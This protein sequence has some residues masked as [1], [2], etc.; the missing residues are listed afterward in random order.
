MIRINLLPLKKRPKISTLRLDLGILGLTLVFLGGAI[1][2]THL[3]IAGLVKKLERTHQ[4]REAENMALMAEVA[5]A[6]RMGNELKVVQDRI[7]VIKGIRKLQSLPVRY[8]DALISVLPEDRLW[9]ETFSLD[10]KGV[11]Q[12]KG[13]AMDNQS[14]ASY[15]EILRTS[16]YVGGVVT[17]RT[18]RREVQGLTLVEFHFRVTFVPPPDEAF[19]EQATH[20]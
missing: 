18:L 5:K 4:A 19:E 11:L 20:G 1:L 12:L 3:W 10:R 16:P 9:F 14:F 2:L 15:V 17:E 8:V 7:E 6:R 13:V